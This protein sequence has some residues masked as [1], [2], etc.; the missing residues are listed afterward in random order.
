MELELKQA[1]LVKTELLPLCDLYC[2]FRFHHWKYRWDVEDQ[3][4]QQNAKLAD[5]HTNRAHSVYGL[6]S[7]P[8]PKVVLLTIQTTCV[9][10]HCT[11]CHR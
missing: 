3:D 5:V 9:L 4:F 2:F 11:T 7:T 8:E 6:P 1:K 10:L